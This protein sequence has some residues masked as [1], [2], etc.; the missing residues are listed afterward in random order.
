[1]GKRS[2]GE[3]A[4][5]GVL[6]TRGMPARFVAGPFRGVAG[7]RDTAAAT[8]AGFLVAQHRGDVFVWPT[9]DDVAYP[10]DVWLGAE[11]DARR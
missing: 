11:H 7:V 6:G 2:A 4:A 10:V 3:G 9:G 5:R 8:P 1:M